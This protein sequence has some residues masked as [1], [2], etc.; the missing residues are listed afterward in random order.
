MTLLFTIKVIHLNRLIA[1][2]TIQIDCIIFKKVLKYEVDVSK[3]VYSKE[4]L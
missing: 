2:S 3:I 1:T 4:E